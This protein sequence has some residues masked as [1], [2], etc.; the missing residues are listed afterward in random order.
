MSQNNLSFSLKFFLGLAAFGLTLFFMNQASEFI[1]QLLLAWIIVLSASPLFYWLR[2]KKAPGWLALVLTL[3][4]IVAVFGFLVVVII[5]AAD[6]LG[7]L[8]G[9]YTEEVED[10]KASVQ[11]FIASLGISQRNA[12]ATADLFD[13][14]AK[15]IDLA[16]DSVGRLYAV[17]TVKLEILVFEPASAEAAP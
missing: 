6:Q 9:T 4:A 3:I 17:D 12:E 16:I 1:V 8:L 7:D 5:I 10:I 13:P 15:N 14:G 11:D 2:Q